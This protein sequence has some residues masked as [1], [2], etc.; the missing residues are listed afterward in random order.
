MKKILRKDQ[1]GVAAIEFSI[2][3]ALLF[4]MFWA[5]ISYSLPFFLL[6]VMNYATAE[7]SRYAIRADPADLEA[8]MI[9]LATEKLNSSLDVLPSAFRAKLES[10]NINVVN[11][12]VTI[13]GK[14]IRELVVR[15]TYSNYNSHPI[16]PT[17]TLPGLG[18]IPNISGDLVAESRLQIQVL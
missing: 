4:G 15:L 6:Q 13:P 9:A 14:T 17:L 10:P 11:D 18:K 2:V 7:A 8:N 3:F 12:T 5:I 1:S 16:I